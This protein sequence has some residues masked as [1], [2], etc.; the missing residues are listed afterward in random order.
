[1]VLLV[2]GQWFIEKV[3]SFETTVSVVINLVGG[4]YFMFLLLRTRIQ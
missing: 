4:L 3:M 1:M 2:S